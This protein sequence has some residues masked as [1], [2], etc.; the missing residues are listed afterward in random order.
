MILSSLAFENFLINFAFVFLFFVMVFYWA[1]FASFFRKTFLKLGQF[2][3][4]FANLLI[5]ASLILRWINSGHFPLSNR[6]TSDDK[7]N[8]LFNYF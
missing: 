8:S 6:S 1:Y 3:N 2:S 7:K 5:F 4:I